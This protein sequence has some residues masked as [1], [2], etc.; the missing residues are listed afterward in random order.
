MIITDWESI[1]IKT[2]IR[3]IYLS[4]TVREASADNDNKN[5]IQQGIAQHKQ[6]C[7][8]IFLIIC[9]WMGLRLLRHS[10]LCLCIII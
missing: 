7:K 3:K 1:C 10:N 4:N 6:S 2:G 5:F 9:V 8:F